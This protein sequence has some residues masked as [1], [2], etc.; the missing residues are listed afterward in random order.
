MGLRAKIFLPLFL[1][2]A[3]CA[4][5][6]TTVWVPQYLGFERRAHRHHYHTDLDILAQNLVRPLLARDL[7]SVYRTLDGMLSRY[8]SWKDIRLYGVDGAQLYPLPGTHGPAASRSGGDM[9]V[10]SAPITHL[11]HPLGRIVL[12]FDMTPL[13]SAAKGRVRELEWVILGALVFA[14]VAIALLLDWLVRKPVADLALAA[15][16]LGEGR[17]QGRLPRPTHDEVGRLVRHFDAM[18]DNVLAARM[19][20]KSS[21]ERFRTL[22]ETSSDWVWEVDRH[23]VYTYASPRAEALLGYESREI[24]GKRMFG[25]MSDDEA[26]RVETLFLD[27]AAQAAPIVGLQS[28]H[29]HKDG[30]TVVLETSGRPFL[31]GDGGLLGYRGISRDITARKLAERAVS[32]SEAKYRAIMEDASDAIFV[33]TFDGKFVDVNGGAERL[34]G[35]SREELL[36][37]HARDI[38]PPSEADNLRAAFRDMATNGHSLYEH[39]VLRKDGTT[40]PVEVAGTLITYHGTD[41]ALGVFRDI[42][43][44]KEA[45][46]GLRRVKEEL[47]QRVRERTTE[48]VDKNHQLEREVDDRAAVEEALRQAMGEL[49]AQKFA[50]DQHAIVAIADRAGRITYANDKFCD[51]S[52]YGRAELIGQDHSVL[53]SGYHSKAFFRDLWRVIGHGR[54]WH[55]EIRNRRK[56][57]SCYWVDTT[58]V[59]FLN[60]EGKPYQYVSIRTDITGRKLTEEAQAARQRRLD[61]Q[62]A[63]LLVLTRD[64]LRDG[65][66]KRAALQQITQLAAETLAVERCGVWDCDTACASSRCSDLF[67]RSAGAHVQGGEL[68]RR[69]CPSFFGSVES[70]HS[71][72]VHQVDGDPRTSEL[73]RAYLAADGVTSLMAMPVRVDGAPVGFVCFE[74]TGEPRHWHADEEQFAGAVAVLLSLLIEQ[75]NRRQAER[76]QADYAEDLQVINDELDRALVK[77]QEAARS[78]S[79]FLATMSHEVRTPMNGILGMLDVIGSTALDEEQQEYVSVARGS[80]QSLLEQLNSILDFA[81]IETGGMELECLEF[82][83]AAAIEDVVVLMAPHGHAKGVAVECSVQPELSEPMFGDPVRLRQVVTNLVSNAIKFTAQGEV[84]IAARTTAGGDGIRWL[85]IEVSDTGIG[86]AAEHQERIFDAFTQAD[87]STTRQYGGTGL[88]LSICRQLARRM[89]GDVGVQSNP[90]EGSTFWFTLP[91]SGDM[92]TCERELSS[93]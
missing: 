78:K 24:I 68:S 27:I 74:H 89:G 29:L 49:Q 26:A 66:E 82:A 8:D 80:A 70:R 92:Q 46:A 43:A 55:G 17:F 62:Q 90:G 33:A 1:V 58:I 19:A 25:L 71:V 16:D 6:I 36:R 84:R 41:V 81:K 85:R 57:G 5:F 72:V 69:D 35:Y 30:R 40:V 93:R 79:E 60:D 51:I 75:Y 14:T 52:Q 28:A 42:S 10:V 91:L 65:V 20:L 31:D 39:L 83:P 53:N 21:E 54:V 38:H 77:A 7:G 45:E 76:K 22:V 9:E 64:A 44:R 23:G 12:R 2:G 87:G 86:I 13:L 63:A 59:P 50:V 3:G 73:A 18:R 4:A 48:L 61:A 88:G 67:L 47:E 34:L 56:D 11:D 32:E 15:A 37:V